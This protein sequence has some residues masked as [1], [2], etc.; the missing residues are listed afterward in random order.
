MPRSPKLTR[1]Q[2]LRSSSL[3]VAG[4]C[5]LPAGARAR[6]QVRPASPPSAPE[7]KR[8]PR[9]YVMGFETDLG[10]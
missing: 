2:W 9:R 10:A 6:V 5:A 4:A 1:R 3:A 8:E 7:Q